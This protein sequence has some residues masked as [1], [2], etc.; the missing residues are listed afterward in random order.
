MNFNSKQGMRLS[1]VLN[2]L[3]LQSEIVFYSKFKGLN[4]L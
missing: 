4:L 2:E 1:T 3:G